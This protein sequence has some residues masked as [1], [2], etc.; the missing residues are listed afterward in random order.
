VAMGV[1][2]AAALAI[3][4]MGPFSLSEA[5]FEACSAFGTV[6][7]STGI[8]GEL[9]VVGHVI[10]V[11]LMFLGRIGPLTLGAALALRTRE[12][13]YRHPEERPIVG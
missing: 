1:V 6:G 10:L 5:L 7:L 4:A 2:T 11:V 3:V 8:T 13:L 12:K 9:P